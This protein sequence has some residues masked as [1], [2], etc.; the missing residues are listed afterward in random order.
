[1][2]KLLIIVVVFTGLNAQITIKECI[3]LGKDINNDAKIDSMTD[4]MEKYV[5]NDCDS[6]IGEPTR[7]KRVQEI[8][9]AFKK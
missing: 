8:K 4:N 2:K 7:E 3:Q 1:M 6:R 5:K 9:D